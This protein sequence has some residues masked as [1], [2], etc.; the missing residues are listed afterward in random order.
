MKELQRQ[1]STDIVI[2]LVGN[3]LDLCEDQN[4]ERQV[5]QEDARAYADEVGLLFFETSA[6]TANNVDDV[7]AEIAKK[8]PLERNYY[9]A[10]GR[11]NDRRNSSLNGGRNVHLMQPT[12][13]TSGS[14]CAC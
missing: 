6:K 5:L 9:S 2:A 8:I 10:G 11:N 13:T 7:F 14:S 1:A 3:K 4:D 12:S